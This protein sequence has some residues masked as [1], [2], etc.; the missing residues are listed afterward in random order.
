[1][2]SSRRL[3]AAYPLPLSLGALDA[4]TSGKNARSGYPPSARCATSAPP[5]TGPAEAPSAQPPSYALPDAAATS[6]TS[7]SAPASPSASD[8]G[9]QTARRS[10]RRDRRP[11]SLA[12]PW[13][14]PRPADFG[15]QYCT[16]WVDGAPA[17][18]AGRSSRRPSRSTGLALESLNRRGQAASIVGKS[19]ARSEADYRGRPARPGPRPLT[20]QR[21]RQGCRRRSPPYGRPCIGTSGGAAGSLAGGVEPGHPD[22]HRA[23][24]PSGMEK[25]P[26]ARSKFLPVDATRTLTSAPAGCSPCP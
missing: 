21:A 6:S 23:P 20:R 26:F 7:S 11:T 12:N 9:R 15:A 18:P 8:R 16:D 5:P 1:M 10:D 25:L 14:A 17:A 4:A 13:G 19:R 24:Q 2:T 22:V 3:T